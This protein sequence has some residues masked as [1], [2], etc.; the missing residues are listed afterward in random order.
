MIWALRSA[1][2]LAALVGCLVWADDPTVMSLNCALVHSDGFARKACQI[3]MTGVVR[4][5]V[6]GL[7][8]LTRPSPAHEEEYVPSSLPPQR[9]GGSAER[10]AG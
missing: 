1:A 9:Q 8:S 10:L 4:A 7:T 3:E 6:R 2:I 5:F